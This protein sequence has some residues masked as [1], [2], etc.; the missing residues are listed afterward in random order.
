MLLV[1]VGAQAAEAVL[2]VVVAV[3][4]AVDVAAGRSYQRSS[5]IALIVLELIVVAGLAWVA[6]GLAQVRPWSRT[7]AAMTQVLTIIVAI[8]LLQA[9]QFDWGGIALLLALAG[10]AGLL[11]PGSLRALA[12]PK[13]NPTVNRRS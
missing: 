12:R 4:N 9:R 11:N 3:V 8:I 5:G 6:V 13:D 7:P 2:L 10:L 1:A